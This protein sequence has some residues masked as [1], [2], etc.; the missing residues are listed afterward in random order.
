MQ[1]ILDHEQWEAGPQTTLGDVLT[2]VSE[3]AH[4]RARL[5][6]TV[7]LDHRRLTDR[8]VDDR[9]LAEPSRKFARLSA[10]SQTVE[11]IVRS[12]QGSIRRYRDTIR[13]EGGRLLSELRGGVRGVTAVD[14]WLGQLADYLELEAAT[15]PAAGS[16][17]DHERLT[18]QVQDLLA[19][20]TA[21]D[22]V[23]LA[24]VL[25]YELLPRLAGS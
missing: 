15:P 19:A 23:R 7:Q 17:A 5:V 1:V 24:D 9:L 10:T 22:P 4:A 16:G 3:R 2:E 13:Q 6:T 20:R 8:D 12:A 25:E 18:R 11:E 14:A 21:D